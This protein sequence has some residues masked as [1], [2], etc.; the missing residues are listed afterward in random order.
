VV[1]DTLRSLSLSAALFLHSH[2]FYR[3]QLSPAFSNAFSIVP[4]PC[5]SATRTMIWNPRP[6]IRHAWTDAKTAWGKISLILFYSL[7]WLEILSAA[8]SI[9]VPTSQGANCLLEAASISA[10]KHA[11]ARALLIATYRAACVITIGFFA[12]ADVGGLQVK[13]VAMVMIVVTGFVLAFL[14]ITSMAREANCRAVI[15]QMWLWPIWAATAL[16]FAIMED[17]LGDHG[18]AE[19]RGNL[20]V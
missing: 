19:E 15:V 7:I 8:W 10:E 11:A 2:Y 18:T 3:R 4:E 5:R 6:H 13:N 16:V 20:V 12:Y 17:K 9:I 14:P 1:D